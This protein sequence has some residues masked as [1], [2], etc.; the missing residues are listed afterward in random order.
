MDLIQLIHTRNGSRMSGETSLCFMERPHLVYD[1]CNIVT[2]LNDQ[3]SPFSQ[4]NHSR[5]L[6]TFYCPPS[7]IRK[8]YATKLRLAGGVSRDVSMS[9]TMFPGMSG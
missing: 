2:L 3:Q 1:V 4:M 9:S 7:Y 8:L 6:A 5:T